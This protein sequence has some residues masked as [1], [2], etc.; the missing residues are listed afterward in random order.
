VSPHHAAALEQCFDD[1]PWRPI[2][3]TVAEPRLRIA[4]SHAEWLVWARL[5]ELKDAWQKPLRW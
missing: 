4:G 3:K 1:L 2:G 5:S